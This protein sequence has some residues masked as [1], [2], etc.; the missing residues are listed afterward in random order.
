MLAKSIR[1][2][3][4]NESSSAAAAEVE[5]EHVKDVECGVCVMRLVFEL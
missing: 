2:V 1:P 5:E 4:V 3:L